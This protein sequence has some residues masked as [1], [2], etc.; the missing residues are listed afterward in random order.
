MTAEQIVALSNA[1]KEFL[2]ARDILQVAKLAVETAKAR[3]VDAIAHAAFAYERLQ[4]AAKAVGL[5]TGEIVDLGDGKCVVVLNQSG[6]DVMNL[7]PPVS[8]VQKRQT[9]PKPAPRRREAS[10]SER[11]RPSRDLTSPPHLP[12][13]RFSA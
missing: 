1:S 3:E 11:Y 7:R 13:A 5:S 8:P 12:K 4:L 2:E 9:P 6:V 10:P